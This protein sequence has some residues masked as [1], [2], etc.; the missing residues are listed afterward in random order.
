[1]KITS[2]ADRLLTTPTDSMRF[3]MP[4][5]LHIPPYISFLQSTHLPV[6][7]TGSEIDL[8]IYGNENY[9][10]AYSALSTR[11]VENI[12]SL[13]LN[14]RQYQV[15]SQSGQCGAQTLGMA[16]AEAIFLLGCERNSD[17]ILGTSYGALIKNYNEAP[18][19]VAVIKHTANEI[20]SP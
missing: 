10:W 18:D 1:M 5:M 9:L 8:H 6:T 16:C 3:T 17:I 11:R 13:W 19:T 12:R 2:T 4:S 15:G 14:M 20:C 7:T